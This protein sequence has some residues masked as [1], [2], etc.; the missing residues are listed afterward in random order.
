MIAAIGQS[1]PKADEWVSSWVE[2]TEPAGGP[3]RQRP[4]YHL[5][6]EFDAPPA[7]ASAYLHATAHGLYE[8]FV[9]G[10]RIDDHELTPGFT[11][12]RKRLQVQTFNVTDLIIEGRN[13]L[14][15][16]LSDGWWRGQNSVARRVDDYG[17]STAFLAQ[18]VV[19]LKS[20]DVVIFGTDF[21]WRSSPSH[22]VRADLI[23]G[24]VHDLRLRVAGWAEPGT[25][26]SS[27]DAVRV[28]DYGFREL[29]VSLAPPVRRIAELRPVSI[30]ELAP[31]RWVVDVGQNSNGWVRLRNLG[32]T[33]TQITLTYGEALDRDGDV[34]QANV[35]GGVSEVADESVTF[36]VD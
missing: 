30:R 35:A 3:G 14:G 4:A 26:R 12:Y 22:V 25:D 36:Q 10:T 13:A 9:N 11:A 15:A 8:A 20:G 28:A 16:I 34:T 19:T 1:M 5:A 18:L 32:P 29:C 27:W 31:L 33:G 21:T 7:I 23:A 17:Y 6:G 2:P 24:E